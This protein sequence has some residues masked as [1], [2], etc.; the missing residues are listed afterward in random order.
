L[1]LSYGEKDDDEEEDEAEEK[2]DG[3]VFE[4]TLLFEVLITFLFPLLCP[5]VLIVG[6]FRVLSL[7]FPFD[8][9]FCDSS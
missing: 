4:L 7:S 1:L 6:V 9:C 3:G 2:D 8:F 5:F